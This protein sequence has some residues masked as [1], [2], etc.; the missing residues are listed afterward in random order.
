MVF[1]HRA[2]AVEGVGYEP[3]ILATLG[4][5]GST[6]EIIVDPI[7]SGG[8]SGLWQQFPEY[9]RRQPNLRKP[10]EKQYNVKFVITTK[11]GK[12][13]AKSYTYTEKQVR[14][15]EKIVARL[16]SITPII[17]DIKIIAN[18]IASRTKEIFVTAK[19]RLNNL[20]P[21]KDNK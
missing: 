10:E 16:R 18:K 13:F 12:K 5:F 3:N 14:R 2:L 15:L 4:V 1:D 11:D 17:D 9:Q 7:P 6:V 21:S 19:Q 20:K 8:G